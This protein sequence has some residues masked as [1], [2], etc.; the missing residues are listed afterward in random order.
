MFLIVIRSMMTFIFK[1]SKG[2]DY[3]YYYTILHAIYTLLYY[4]FIS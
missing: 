2:A 3:D 4:M 1:T